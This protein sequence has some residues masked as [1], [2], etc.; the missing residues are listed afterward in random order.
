MNTSET[1]NAG[2]S[3]SLHSTGTTTAIPKGQ[4]QEWG[5][6]PTMEQAHLLARSSSPAELWQ[7]LGW[8]KVG[9]YIAGLS[10]FLTMSFFIIQF[11]A[12][13][14]IG[15]F[16]EW[17]GVQWF[18]A[19]LGALLSASITGFQLFLFATGQTKQALFSVVVAV[20]FGVFCEV[21]ATMDREQSTVKH[22]SAQSG[23][24]QETIKAIGS[25]SG[26][27]ATL[28]P[29]QV[30]L[31]E[32]Q[33]KLKGWQRDGKPHSPRSVENLRMKIESL[34]AQSAMASTQQ[35]GA[36]QAT[37]TTAKQLEQDEAN[38][39]QMIRLFMSFG[40]SAVWASFCFSLVIIG[41]FEY[42]FHYMG[43]RLALLKLA[44]YLLGYDTARNRPEPPKLV[45]DTRT[46]ASHA[47][48][49]AWSGLSLGSVPSFVGSGFGA[50]L[51][52]PPVSQWRNGQDTKDTGGQTAESKAGI[53][54]CN[55]WTGL[56]GSCNTGTE[57]E[58]DTE[59]KD[60]M[61]RMERYKLAD[62]ARVG[63]TVGCPWCGESFVKKTYNHRFC[64]VPHRD[65]YWNHLKP[66]R[67]LVKARKVGAGK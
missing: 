17:Q 21:S 61:E 7:Q 54:P 48:S 53:D 28:S 52:V 15:A 45:R 16:R 11:F 22:R 37:I 13:A 25:L 1:R 24:Y 47:L 46:G 8:A 64:C 4:A 65:E 51:S 19:F 6:S 41:V 12:G 26:A 40:L 49:P 2:N 42:A 35:T 56:D 5:H 67:L 30:S 43:H 14:D 50:G 33:A 10:A 3:F 58:E 29:S 66:E 9:F 32:N 44:L 59:D 55:T 39:A 62:S 23:V 20:A 60:N 18:Y 34:K 63:Q 36:L 31:S 57:Q 27:S 38:H